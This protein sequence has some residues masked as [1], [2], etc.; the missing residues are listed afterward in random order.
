MTRFLIA[1]LVAAGTV[2][3]AAPALADLQ[4]PRFWDRV[5]DRVDR[6]ENRIDRRYTWGP[7]D[8][9]EDR[10]DRREDRF[11]RRHDQVVTPIDRWG[12]RHRGW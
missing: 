5:E 4:H 7:A 6:V 8:R 12:W 2:S 3:A 10:I 1:A 11:D 9:I